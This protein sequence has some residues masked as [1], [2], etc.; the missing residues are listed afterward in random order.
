MVDSTDLVTLEDITD[1]GGEDVVVLGEGGVLGNDEDD[2]GRSNAAE[3]EALGDGVLPRSLG[4][5]KATEYGE[6]D[7]AVKEETLDDGVDDEGL[8]DSDA[9]EYVALGD[10]ALPRKMPNLGDGEAT[11]NEDLRGDDG[12]VAVASD[13]AVGDVAAVSAGH[14]VLQL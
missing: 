9:A 8:D 1:P 11:E 13:D 7:A 2:L 14:S 6:G 10:G 4:D 5:G 12:N 3:Y